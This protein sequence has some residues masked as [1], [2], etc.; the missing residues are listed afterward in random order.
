MKD[1]VVYVFREAVLS[2]LFLEVSASHIS[3]RELMILFS[4]RKKKNL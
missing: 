3:Q 4:P 2:L 1:T